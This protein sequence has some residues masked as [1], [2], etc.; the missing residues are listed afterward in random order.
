MK[1]GFCK[2]F[3]WGIFVC[4]CASLLPADALAKKPGKYD[5]RHERVVVNNIHI[6]D[7]HFAYVRKNRMTMRDL[8]TAKAIADESRRLDTQDVLRLMKRG[9]SYRQIAKKYNVKWRKVER[10]V[11]ES[12]KDMRRE[13]IK[14]GLAIWAL[15]E[16]L[17]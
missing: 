1:K 14:L 17:N 4:F 12:Y 8:I 2:V 7:R 13:A 11:D 10:R 5:S 3:A 9:Y 15:D 16:I 6:Q